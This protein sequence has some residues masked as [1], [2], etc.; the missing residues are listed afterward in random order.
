MAEIKLLKRI[1]AEQDRRIT[2]LE[3][4]VRT[5]QATDPDNG[6]NNTDPDNGQKNSTGKKRILREFI[7]PPSMAWMTPSAWVRVK[8]GM[9]RSQVQ[10]IL[11]KPTSIQTLPG[12][13]TLFYQGYGVSGSSSVTGTVELYNDRVWQVNIPVF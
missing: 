12:F 10:A 9:S 5:L 8:E 1:V 13:Q 7:P 2:T 11:G 4:T 3:Q 6:Q